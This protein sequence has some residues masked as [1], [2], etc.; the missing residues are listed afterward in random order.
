MEGKVFISA[1]VMKFELSHNQMSFQQ[2]SVF[3][4]LNGKMTIKKKLKSYLVLVKAKTTFL[5]TGTKI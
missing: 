1:G 2:G 4:E 5:S 3:K